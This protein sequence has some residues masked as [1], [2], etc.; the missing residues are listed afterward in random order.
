[1]RRTHT[2]GLSRKRRAYY[3]SDS[4]QSAAERPQVCDGQADVG[5]GDEA[6]ACWSR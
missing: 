1:M 5:T 6:F 4:D 2:G 3:A